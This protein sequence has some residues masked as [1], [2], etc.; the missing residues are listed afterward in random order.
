MTP[1]IVLVTIGI[2]MM[3]Q[4]IGL[5]LGAGSIEEYTDPTEA[6]LAMGARLNEAKG[7]MTLLVGVILLAS[8]NIDSNSAKK[9][10]FGTGI[11]MAICCVFSAERHVN[12]VWNDEGGPPLL[13][14]IVFGLLALWSF[15]VSL[16][17][18]SSE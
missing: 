18:D 2:L 13:I 12:Q 5:F 15:Y 17:K 6:M 7:L 14:P 10:V 9:V 16:K 4:G 3:L 1:K 11:A 8:F